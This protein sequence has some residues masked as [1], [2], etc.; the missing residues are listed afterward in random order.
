MSSPSPTLSISGTP[1][2]A[3]PDSAQQEPDIPLTLASSM[4]LTALPRDAAT[5]L[6]SAGEF[7][8]PKIAVHFKPV[9]SAPSLRN[10]VCKISSAQRFE[11]VVTYLR[12]TL[13]VAEA[14]SVFLYV[15]SS[16][17][18]ALD[19]VVGNLHRCFKDSKDQL[20]VTYS[21]TPAFG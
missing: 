11:V 21:M 19:E 1:P 4:I 13:K 5:A 12:R 16:F 20:V 18:P 14:E 7:P 10:Q 8:K 9:G 2:E 6:S 15:N 3:I 17:A